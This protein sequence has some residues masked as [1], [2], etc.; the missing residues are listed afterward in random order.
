M[1]LLKCVKLQNIYEKKNRITNW[2]L[3]HCEFVTDFTFNL[4]L[5]KIVKNSF[6]AARSKDAVEKVNK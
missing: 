4:N 5:W 1:E 3:G 6:L 2:F